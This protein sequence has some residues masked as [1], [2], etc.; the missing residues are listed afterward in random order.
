MWNTTEK[1]YLNVPF[2]EKDL[3]KSRGAK[4][5]YNKK[6]WYYMGEDSDHKFDR[7][8]PNAA[9]KPML[10]IDNLSGEQRTLVDYAKLGK[11]A[12]VDACIGSGK[13]TTIQVLCNELPNL[14]ILYLTYNTLLK[15]DAKEKIRSANTFVTN[16]HGFA[17]KVLSDAGIKC[18][19]SDLVQTFLARKDELNIPYYD[20]VLIDEYQDIEQEIADML[21]CLKAA[22]PNIQIIAVGDMKQKIYDKTTLKVP[23]FVDRYLGDD[24][25]LLSF[26]KCFRLSAEIAAKLGR[27]WGKEIIGVNDKCKVR[28]MPYSEVEVYLSQQKTSDVLCLGSRTG[29]MSRMLN[30]L[31]KNCPWKYNKNTVYASIS[32]EDRSHRTMPDSS[33][34][35]FTTFDSSK[36]L[37]RPICV[38]F[39]YTTD[40]WLTRLEK[41]DAN[42]EILKNIFCVAASRGK[43][44]IIFVKEPLHPLLSEEDITMPVMNKC[45][46]SRPFVM[47]DMFS[48]KYKENVEE[49][50]RLLKTTPVEVEDK[51]PIGVKASDG[52]IDLSPCVG[53]LQEAMFF[54]NYNIDDEIF[55][56]TEH[57]KDRPPLKIKKGATLEEKILYLVA[58]ETYQDR[59]LKQVTVPFVADETLDA[60][61]NR[62]STKFKPTETIQVP[63]SIPYF[64]NAGNRRLCEGRCDVLKDDAVWELK[65][66]TELSHEHYLQCACYMVGLGKKKG[67]LWNVR[68]NEIVEIEIPDPQK[69]MVAV[70][71]TI[72][73]TNISAAEFPVGVFDYVK[74]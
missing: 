4:W 45:D 16:Y 9:P 32:D 40:Y 56:A 1:V 22:N 19:V 28:E 52:Y 8:K 64:D 48:F 58:Y 29:G 7:W 74:E 15:V 38:V 31:E 17:Y 30:N 5:D 18:G 47:S 43:S 39:D 23:E 61:R 25:V 20:L 24:Y 41:P 37:E 35:I 72:T 33:T 46:Y 69:F 50:F 55:F 34:A 27:I 73:K 6:Q 70:I 10:T 21:E 49:C 68:T 63:C 11:N 3:A 2:L 51:T 71:N 42:Y 57:Y 14:Q 13:T 54:E 59:Y 44:E 36:G 60:I 53:I 66:V 67:V 12:L 62:L 65:F 26:T